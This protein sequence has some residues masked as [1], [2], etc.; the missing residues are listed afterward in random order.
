LLCIR[1]ALSDRQKMGAS[2]GITIT[3]SV[4][5]ALHLVT[6]VLYTKR[7]YDRIRSVPH[8]EHRLAA[9]FALMLLIIGAI[10]LTTSAVVLWFIRSYAIDGVCQPGAGDT[11][12]CFVDL[13]TK[14]I[15]PTAL[16]S[17]VCALFLLHVAAVT[18]GSMA[19]IASVMTVGSSG[20]MLVN[21]WAVAL[22]LMNLSHIM[23]AVIRWADE[24]QQLQLNEEHPFCKPCTAPCCKSCPVFCRKPCVVTL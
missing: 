5:A 12:R 4:W 3:T 2:L 20:S 10:F 15:L 16:A 23:M 1:L 9:I 8:W 18:C 14:F 22:L 21:L 19:F 17:S 13:A 11:Y 7:F 6:V 24:S